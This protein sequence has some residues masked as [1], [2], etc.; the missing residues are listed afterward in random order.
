MSDYT[1]QARIAAPP[2][3][4]REALTDPAALRTWLAEHAEVSLPDG[5]FSFWGRY[6]PQGERGRQRL[7][8]EGPDRLCFSWTLDEV[9]TEVE[10]SW[11]AD[12]SNNTVLTLTQ[13][14]SPPMEELMAPTGRR[15]G[16]HSVHTFW[17]LALANLAAYVE[18]RD[19]MPFCDFSPDRPHEIRFEL[20]IDGSPEEVFASLTEPD[21]VERW[22]GWRVEVEPRVG[23]RCTFGV[24][25]RIF[26]FEPGRRFSYGDEHG[27]VVRWELASS[28][29]GTYLSFV[30]SG[31]A[32]DE[33]D[34]AAQ[35][36]AGWLGGVAELRRM[37]ELGSAY[38]PL[39][40]ETELPQP[41]DTTITYQVRLEATTDEAFEALTEDRSLC[42]WF[43]E[44]AEV[45]LPDGEFSFWGQYTPEGEPGRQRLL[46]AIPGQL[47][48][49]GWLLDG[50]E[51]T[52]SIQLA[53]GGPGHTIATVSQSDCV[54][55]QE[56]LTGK[57]R[58][59][60]GVMHTFW[61][62]S[63]ANLADYLVG[64]RLT[65]M[66]DYTDDVDDERFAEVMLDAELDEVYASIAD[67]DRFAD[68]FGARPSDIILDGEPGVV[69]E[70]RPGQ[71]IT[72]SWGEAGMVRWE[73][74]GSEGKTSLTFV[75]SGFDRPA[76]LS[77]WA[78]WL[79]GI[80][81]LRRMHELGDAWRPITAGIDAPIE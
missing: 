25:G 27:A 56:V 67:E 53:P 60:R 62:L 69:D 71:E 77:G 68:W 5:E 70:P 48:R 18:G 40:V 10:L 22:F 75:Q 44:Y 14:D 52:V 30:Q 12:Q 66:C 1:V 42:I 3:R 4:V 24:D 46:E 31:F 64:R 43:A 35:H 16:L 26:E 28:D 32:T 79:S 65:P 57:S 37:Y 51:T 36:E 34:N 9:E 73:L 11:A 59:V 23:G 15:D 13:S 63:M 72:F 55:Y 33:L 49:F 80:A 45:S 6:T 17:S 76:D 47:L 29:G 38:Q 81:E 7:R 41:D 74:A 20:Q 50:V 58:S 8:A 39:I 61:A 78:G 2:A 54:P 21:Q 19:L